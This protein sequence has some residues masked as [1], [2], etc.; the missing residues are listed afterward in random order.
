MN[1]RELA[2]LLMDYLDGTLPP[3]HHQQMETHLQKCPPCLTYLETYR[4]TIQMTRRLPCQ[5]MPPQLVER[6][7]AAFIEIRG[8]EGMSGCGG[9]S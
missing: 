2:E 6:L 4:I 5:P 8:G 1:C 9:R 7:K 3:E